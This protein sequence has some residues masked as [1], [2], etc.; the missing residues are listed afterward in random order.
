M[1]SPNQ[2]SEADITDLLDANLRMNIFKH[3]L[4][5]RSGILSYYKFG[6][7][8]GYAPDALIRNMFK[9]YTRTFATQQVEEFWKKLED[10]KMITTDVKNDL[11][12]HFVYTFQVEKAEGIF[13]HLNPVKPS[14]I[15]NMVRMYAQIPDIKKIKHILDPI[16]DIESFLDEPHAVVDETDYDTRLELYLEEA[17]ELMPTLKI[18]RPR[19]LSH[20]SSKFEKR[21]GD[22]KEIAIENYLSQGNRYHGS[23]QPSFR[24]YRSLMYAYAKNEEPLNTFQLFNWLLQSGKQVHTHHANLLLMT[25]RTKQSQFNIFNKLYKVIPKNAASYNLMMLHAKKET[26]E[27]LFNEMIEAKFPS[28]VMTKNLLTYDDKNAKHNPVYQNLKWYSFGRDIGEI[29]R[30]K[31]KLPSTKSRPILKEDD[32]IG[33]VADPSIPKDNKLSQKPAS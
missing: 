17:L 19:I 25:A 32:S 15:E 27:L 14:A 6:N 7:A 24:L 26:R 20:R 4:S 33:S 5:S 30:L 2:F 12:F 9:L 1:Q 23:N 29:K 31:L 11:L 18:K 3:N 8:I 13:K 10:R 28:T 16:I 21:F 22:K